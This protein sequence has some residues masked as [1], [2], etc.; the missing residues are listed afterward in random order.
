M[1]MVVNGILFGVIQPAAPSENA[2]VY[3]IKK[4]LNVFRVYFFSF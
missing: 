3:Y 2:E 1:P 4:L